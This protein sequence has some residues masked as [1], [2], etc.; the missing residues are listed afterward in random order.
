MSEAIIWMNGESYCAPLD[1][2][3]PGLVRKIFKSFRGTTT[4][5]YFARAWVA[6]EESLKTMTFSVQ[7]LKLFPLSLKLC[8]NKLQCL[9]KLFVH[10]CIRER[11]ELLASHSGQ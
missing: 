3:A 7:V 2:K 11:L 4:L 10:S 1:G 8:Q 5:A 6:K 9:L